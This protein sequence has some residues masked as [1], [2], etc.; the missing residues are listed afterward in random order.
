MES[1][2]QIEKI[3]SEFLDNLQAVLSERDYVAINAGCQP[4]SPVEELELIPKRRYDLMN[5]HFQQFGT[6]GMEMMRGTSSLQISIDYR[7]EEDFRRKIQSAYYYGPVLKLLCDHSDAFQGEALD[8]HLK[9]T[10]IWRRVDPKR[11]GILPKVF[12]DSY[13][14]GDYADFL[15][16]MPPIFLK[17]GKKI[18]P[19]GSRT[20]AELYNGK[21]MSGEEIAHILSMAFPDVR[22]KQYLEIRF[23]DSVPLPFVPAYCALVKG[24]LYSEEGL[25]FAQQQIHGNGITEQEIRQAESALI[26]QGWDACIY[27]QPVRETAEKLLELAGPSLPREER[28]F[29]AAF[30][31]VIEA[32]GISRIPP[33]TDCIHPKKETDL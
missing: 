9:R 24:L 17:Q 31:T 8:S 19:T 26:E 4:V 23:A 7:S 29:L 14:Y 21:E 27:G 28:R 6:G 10:D 22:L 18:L 3:Y 5:A 2:S 30:Q 15:G 11:C 32:G 16:A 25:A 13:G 33:E 20:V 1:V 12:S